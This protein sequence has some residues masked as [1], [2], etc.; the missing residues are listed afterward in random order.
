MSPHELL[1]RRLVALLKDAANFH[2]HDF[3]APGDI[4]TPKVDLVMRLNAISEQVKRGTYDDSPDEYD[5]AELLKICESEDMP[6]AM[7][8]ALGLK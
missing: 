6:E 4:A 1:L 7:I 8:K 2:F 5:V 3:K